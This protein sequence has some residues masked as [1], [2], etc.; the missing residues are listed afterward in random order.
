[1]AFIGSIGNGIDFGMASGRYP[2]KRLSTRHR[3]YG[4]FMA[5]R[6]IWNGT[7]AFGLVRVPIKLYSAIDPKGIAFREIHTRDQ[8][9][10]KHRLVCKK[11]G[12]VV[13]RSEVAKGYEVRAD[14]YV[15]LDA[16]EIKAASGDRPK[17]I[18]V[19][20]FVDVDSIDPF[21]FTKSYYL[22]VRDSS[23]PY[24][25]FAAA[26]S[27]TGKAGI[28][29]FTFHNREY[30]C[31]IRADGDRLMLHT[32]RFDDEVIKPGDI[33][34]PEGGKEPTKKEVTLARKL[35][36]GLTEDFEP[37]EFEDEYRSAVMD[38]I[39]RK[40]AGKKTPSKRRKKRQKA[41]DLSDALEKS[42]AAQGAKA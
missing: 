30:L 32:L 2:L 10:L 6:S 25:V 8:S 38:L 42:L 3:G 16:E 21:F 1:M 26:L 12:K 37:G 11:E 17:T 22:G 28:G 14:Q 29:R 34:L 40:A 19:E 27:E 9:L 23:E 15:L 36:Q 31:A 39:D 18:E 13:E 7:V 33:D 4:G 35:V 5:P 24:A 20:E 41:G